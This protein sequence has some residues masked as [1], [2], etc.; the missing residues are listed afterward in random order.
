MQ[1]VKTAGKQYRLYADDGK[2]LG[3][4]GNMREAKKRQ[5]DRDV[6]LKATKKKGRSK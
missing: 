1:I 2:V 4:F 3:T 5:I 6:Y